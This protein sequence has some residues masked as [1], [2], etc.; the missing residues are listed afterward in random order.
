MKCSIGII[1]NSV[2]TE[3]DW[4]STGRSVCCS[5]PGNKYSGSLKEVEGL[6][7]LKD[8]ELLA[9]GEMV[10]QSFQI[11]AESCDGQIA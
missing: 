8:S 3:F 6:D 11:L 1:K 7:Y 9:H 10:L 5:E 2:W 4:L